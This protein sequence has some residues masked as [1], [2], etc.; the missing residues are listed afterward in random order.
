M[1]KLCGVALVG[2]PAAALGPCPVQREFGG[3]PIPFPRSREG[4]C[5]CPL[6]GAANMVVLARRLGMP[7]A[8]IPS[9]FRGAFGPSPSPAVERA[10][11]EIGLGRYYRGVPLRE[12]VHYGLCLRGIRYAKGF[13]EADVWDRPVSWY[14]PPE[15]VTID[16]DR[17]IREGRVVAAPRDEQM[18]PPEDEEATRLGL[19]DWLVWPSEDQGTEDDGAALT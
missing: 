5:V 13:T 12:S 18:P 17:S 1:H 3:C 19:S 7:R 4:S 15:W 14:E 11:R 8:P 16:V 2:R 6:L 9:L 10:A